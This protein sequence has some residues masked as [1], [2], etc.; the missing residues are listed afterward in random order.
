MN[1][2]KFYFEN[3]E[4]YQRGLKFAILQCRI[5]SEFPIKFSKIRD[6]LIGAGIS[7][8]LNI[9][10]GSG[11]ISTQDKKHFYKISRASVFEC[12]AIIEICLRLNLIKRDI[13]D[14]IRQEAL[15]LSKMLM[16]L[17]KTTQ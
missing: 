2:E 1:N 13:H 9:A 16:G 12:V 4:V 7:I 10:E 11:R 14:S 6:Q 3:L 15:E 8:P 5:A 17:A